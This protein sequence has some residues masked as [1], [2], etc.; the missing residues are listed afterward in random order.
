[1]QKYEEFLELKYF[2]NIDEILKDYIKKRFDFISEIVK[3]FTKFTNEKTTKFKVKISFKI[4]KK[5][6]S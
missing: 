3:Q 2:N 6:I 5:Q 1:M 4:H